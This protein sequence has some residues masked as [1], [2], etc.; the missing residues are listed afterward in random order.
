MPVHTILLY[1][2]RM[3]LKFNITIGVIV[4]TFAGFGRN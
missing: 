4:L 1:D 2:F 3:T